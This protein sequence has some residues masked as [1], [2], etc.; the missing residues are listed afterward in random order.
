MHERIEGF[1]ARDPSSIWRRAFFGMRN[2]NRQSPRGQNS[3]ADSGFLRKLFE[4]PDAKCALETLDA[5]GIKREFVIRL[6]SVI[7]Q[8]ESDPDR[9]LL[10][11]P[12]TLKHA[13]KRIQRMGEEIATYNSHP[14]LGLDGS[15]GLDPNLK[16]L[17]DGM[18]I[19]LASYSDHLR[20]LAE[21]LAKLGKTKPSRQKLLTVYWLDYAKR[22]TG[23]EHYDEIACLLT[24]ARAARGSTETTEPSAL[25]MSLARY[26]SSMFDLNFTQSP[27]QNITAD[28]KSNE[29]PKR[30][31]FGQRLAKTS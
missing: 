27:Q 30:L 2:V 21:R 17:F 3:R 26:R 25:R 29:A 1:L 14:I 24:A 15:L 23:D 4:Q 7:T 10:P 6:L 31:T 12:K 19:V 22:L 16:A 11:N 5:G 8:S 13:A 20:V 9:R 18:P 28:S